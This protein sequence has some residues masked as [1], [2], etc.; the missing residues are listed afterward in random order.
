MDNKNDIKFTPNKAA[1]NSDGR[2]V[3]V[4]VRTKDVLESWKTSMF[5]FEWLGTDGQIK[6]VSELPEKELE[7]R[8]AIEEKIQNGEPLEKPVL[9]IGIQDNVEIGSGRVQFLVLADL[10]LETIPV[11]I[12]KSNESDFKAFLTDVDS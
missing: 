10:G 5:S 12:P 6:P 7:K 4:T 1:Q 8:K 3:E 9:G 2:Y 11:H